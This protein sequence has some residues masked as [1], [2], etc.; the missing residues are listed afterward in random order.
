MTYRHNAINKTLLDIDTPVLESLT[1]VYWPFF[2]VFPNFYKHI[3]TFR[4]LPIP[5]SFSAPKTILKRNCRPQDIASDRE[6]LSGNLSPPKQHVLGKFEQNFFLFLHRK[7]ENIKT[8]RGVSIVE[9]L[10]PKKIV[11]FRCLF[12]RALDTQS[13][14]RH[15][16]Q[17]FQQAEISHAHRFPLEEKRFARETKRREVMKSGCIIRW[18]AGIFFLLQS[19]QVFC[20]TINAF[21]KHLRVYYSSINEFLL[22]TSCSVIFF[23][24]RSSIID[25]YKFW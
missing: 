23:A 21:L 11:F 15:S 12:Q 3:C 14:R 13:T 19:Q 25:P 6:S 9:V 24:H 7:K 18:L 1:F 5:F 17:R 22:R 4:T 2:F 10:Q 20:N 16:T 8:K